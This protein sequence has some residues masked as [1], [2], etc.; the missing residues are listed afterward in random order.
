MRRFI[1]EP[2]A[3]NVRID[4]VLSRMQLSATQPTFSLKHS[5]TKRVGDGDG[6]LLVA[7]RGEPRSTLLSLSK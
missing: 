5:F 2:F 4:L 1:E 3:F 7:K 6:V